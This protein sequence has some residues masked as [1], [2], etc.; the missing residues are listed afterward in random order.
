MKTLI[1]SKEIKRLHRA[2]ALALQNYPA[3]TQFS[4][5]REEMAEL[6][7]ALERKWRN[8]S[9]DQDILEE[10]VDVFM[11]TVQM[12]AHHYGP[13]AFNAMLKKKTDKFEKKVGV[14][15]MI[16]TKPKR[17]KKP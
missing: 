11:C 15:A 12:G 13:D 7:L 17:V 4:H 2:C 6:F 3:D 1:D 16:K 14:G 9:T 8:R 10:I 5:L